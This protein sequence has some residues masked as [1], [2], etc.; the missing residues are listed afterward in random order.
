MN[1][2]EK[3]SKNLNGFSK[4]E[5]KVAEVILAAPQT[6]IHSS[7]AALAKLADVSEPTVN[8]FCRR[9]DTKGFP[10]FK[11]HLAQSLANGTPYVNRHVEESDGPDAYTSKIFETAMASLDTARNSLD[12]T[13]INRAVDILTQANK[14]SFFGL[15]ASASVAHDAT[16]KF[17]R[18]N[19]P[20]VFF[21]DVLMQ[22]MSCI[23]SAEGDVIVLISHTGRTK[24]LVELAQLARESG[25]T[26]I[27]I[28]SKDSPLA[29]EANLILA[30]DVPEDTDI[31]MPMASRLA[32]LCLVDVL[33]TGFTLRRGPRFR[34]NLRKVKESLKQSRFNKAE[35]D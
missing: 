8:R 25:A 26:V 15:G 29:Q 1:T 18:F 14:I 11:L 9:L 3:I 10:D 34:D 12:A 32:Q 24:S 21:E 6:A 35:Y 20:V 19:V 4:S 17:F 28:T 16:N 2:L 31:Y 7:I 23:N 22:R 5:R 13:Q 27:A 30:M 33:A